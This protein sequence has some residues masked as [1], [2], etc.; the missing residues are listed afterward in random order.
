MEDFSSL[1]YNDTQQIRGHNAPSLNGRIVLPWKLVD[2]KNFIQQSF[3]HVFNCAKSFLLKQ[4]VYLQYNSIH[5]DFYLP[6]NNY[7]VEPP[8]VKTNDYDLKFDMNFMQVHY[9]GT[10]IQTRI[11]MT[12]QEKL[13]FLKIVSSNKSL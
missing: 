1:A 6:M 3:Y 9:N 13:A 5:S 10:K 11:F 7:V 2:S 8:F 12:T 4:K